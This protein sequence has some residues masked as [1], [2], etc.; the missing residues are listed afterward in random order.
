M[1]ILWDPLIAFAVFKCGSDRHVLFST[2]I[3]ITGNCGMFR[4][5]R[6]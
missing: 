6:I 5:I 3:I 1:T 2:V 4:D